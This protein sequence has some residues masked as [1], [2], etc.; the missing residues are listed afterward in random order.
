MPAGDVDPRRAELGDPGQPPPDQ[1]AIAAALDDEVGRGVGDD[2]HAGLDAFRDDALRVGIVRGRQRAD[3]T[4]ADAAEVAALE[5]RVSHH[6]ESSNRTVV[7]L[8]DVQVEVGVEPLCQLEAEPY[9][10][11]LV[12]LRRLPVGH[13]AHHVAA[14]LHGRSHQVQGARVAKDALLRKGN[15]LN[16]GVTGAVGGSREHSLQRPE[17]ADRV[18]IHV[19][20]EAGRAGQHPA[21]DHGSRPAANVLDVVGTLARLDG[22]DR[23]GERAVV[24]RQLVADQRLVEVHVGVDVG[25]QQQ[26]VSVGARCFDAGDQLAVKCHVHNRARRQAH[27]FN[28]RH[29]RTY[30]NGA[31]RPLSS[32][33]CA[34]LLSPRASA[35][36][37]I[38]RRGCPGRRRS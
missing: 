27:T 30:D 12:G 25:R 2:G 7:R 20:A 35:T 8:V 5:S 6:L 9:V 34:W 18:D 31:L 26:L 24:L 36:S 14:R 33:G 17:P 28:S 21:F 38:P 37:S 15:G 3:V 23:A 11:A 10:L 29:E 13:A 32:R 22:S 4:H 16:L 19:R 1:P